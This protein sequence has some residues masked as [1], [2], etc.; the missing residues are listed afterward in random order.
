MFLDLLFEVRLKLAEEFEVGARME[1]L[2]APKVARKQAPQVF[3][4]GAVQE[5][6][7]I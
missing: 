5:D 4:L 1:P 2:H 6:T 7:D 3:I